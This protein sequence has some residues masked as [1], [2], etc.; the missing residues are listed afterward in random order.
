M[1]IKHISG[2]YDIYVDVESIHNH[3]VQVRYTGPIGEI[4]IM[5]RP[6]TNPE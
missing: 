3:K 4:D 6:I 5:G 1:V 2:G